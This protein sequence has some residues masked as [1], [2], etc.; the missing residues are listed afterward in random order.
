MANERKVTVFGAGIM[1]S[2]I[3]EVLAEAGHQV[4]L[5]DP[6]IDVGSLEV[7]SRPNVSVATDIGEAVEGSSLLIEAIVEDLSAKSAL[8]AQIEKF[9]GTTPIASNTSTFSPTELANLLHNPSR[10][11]ITHFFNPAATVPLVEVAGSPFTSA[12]AIAEVTELLE[13]ASKVV[14]PLKKETPGLIANRLQAALI[15]EALSLVREGI[16]TEVDNDAAVTN[17]IG[18]RWAVAGPFEIM[19][20]GGLDTWRAVCTRLFPEL[21]V[22]IEPPAEIVTLVEEGRLGA[23]SGSGFYNHTPDSRTEAL[24]R[25]RQSFQA[26]RAV[27]GEHTADKDQN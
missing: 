11:L 20:L 12:E 23:K 26:R 19:D 8:F 7:A 13:G 6:H 10:L 4:T 22:D 21:S 27:V 24:D 1:G 14:V 3:A 25:V 2:E 9:D 5:C 16:A 17:S 18:P 15:R